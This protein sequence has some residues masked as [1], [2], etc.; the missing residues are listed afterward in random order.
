[1]KQAGLNGKGILCLVNSLRVR[2]IALEQTL[3]RVVVEKEFLVIKCE[4][5]GIQT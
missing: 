3:G 5:L 1:M 4:E 2:I